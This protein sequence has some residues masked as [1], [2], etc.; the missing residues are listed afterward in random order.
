[1]IFPHLVDIEKPV[2]TQDAE[3]GE[4]AVVWKPVLQGVG[5][6]IEDVSVRQFIQ[7]AA[8]QQEVTTMI[9]IPFMQG[10]E[11]KKD[12]RLKGADGQ[13]FGEIYNPQGFLRDNKGGTMY[14]TIP[15]ER[16]VNEGDV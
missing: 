3:T 2:Q 16:G 6:K 13:H 11:L 1:M 10:V 4:V 9:T 15:C 8:M 7:S 5:C 12:M 14:I